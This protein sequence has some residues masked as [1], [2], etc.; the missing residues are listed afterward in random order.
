[1]IKDLNEGRKSLAVI[2]MGYVGLPIALELARKMKVIGFDI[3]DDR[4]EMMKKS[5]DPSGEVPSEAF[6][7]CDIH[8]TASEEDLAGASFYIVAVPTPIDEHNSI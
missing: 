1:M 6:L 7:D 8:Y 3:K 5:M 2:G 4:I